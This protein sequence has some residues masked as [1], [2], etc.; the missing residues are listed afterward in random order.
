[1]TTDLYF[2]T[3]INLLWIIKLFACECKWFANI[4]IYIFSL[5]TNVI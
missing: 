4:E 2:R 3:D 1:M 5:I